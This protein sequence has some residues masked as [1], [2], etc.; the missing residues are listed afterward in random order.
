MAT[1][2][3]SNDAAIRAIQELLMARC[4]EEPS[5]LL[6]LSDPNKPID[7][8]VNYLCNVIQ[9]MGVCMVDDNTVLG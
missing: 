8:A 9:K 7:K 6:K 4:K 2:M 5:F 1:T 3:K